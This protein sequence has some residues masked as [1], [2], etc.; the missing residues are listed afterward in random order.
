MQNFVHSQ[1][2]SSKGLTVKML[3]W[4]HYLEEEINCQETHKISNSLS[5]QNKMP[6]QD[7]TFLISTQISALTFLVLS[8]EEAVPVEFKEYS[9]ICG[10]IQPQEDNVDIWPG[11][12]VNHLWVPRICIQT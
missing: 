9:L 6:F 8:G 10:T 11:E 12:G 5:Q 2:E 3:S 4:I 1:N 7:N